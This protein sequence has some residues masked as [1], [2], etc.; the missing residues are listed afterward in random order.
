MGVVKSEHEPESLREHE[1]ELISCI[2]SGVCM[3][4]PCVRANQINVVTMLLHC[5][6]CSKLDPP[7][8][9]TFCN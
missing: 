6:S 1:H 7:W 5:Y 4:W 8:S 9:S 3:A 2:V